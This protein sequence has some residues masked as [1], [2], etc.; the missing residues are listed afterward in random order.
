MG[1]TPGPAGASNGASMKRKSKV[2]ASARWIRMVWMLKM[3]RLVPPPWR[4][5]MVGF[6]GVATALGVAK[7]PRWIVM[8]KDCS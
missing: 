3:V 1:F 7:D 5:M 2:V 8:V 6:L 4:H